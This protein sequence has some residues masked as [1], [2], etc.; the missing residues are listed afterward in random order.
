MGDAAPC[1]AASPVLCESDCGKQKI[2]DVL[3]RKR[4]NPKID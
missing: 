1:G 4:A 2:S 3:I